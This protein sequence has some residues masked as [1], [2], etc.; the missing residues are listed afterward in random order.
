MQDLRS[1]FREPSDTGTRRQKPTPDK[2]TLHETLDSF[3]FRKDIEYHG[4][5][6]LPLAAVREANSLLKRVD[7]SC[8]QT[9]PPGRG[10][11]K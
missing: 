5:K 8:L 11:Q 6:V 1:A 10:Q 9:Y 3:V 4:A 2:V 7:R